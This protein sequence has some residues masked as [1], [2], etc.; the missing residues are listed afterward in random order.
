MVSD[1]TRELVRRGQQI[2]DERL[3][4]LL[5][6]AHREQFVAIEPESGDYFLGET[7]SEAAAAA[8]KAYPQRRTYIVRVGYSAAVE[9]GAW[10]P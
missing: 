5:D 8:E 1:E 6:P 10:L 2:Y 3:K 4:A 7:L 9:I